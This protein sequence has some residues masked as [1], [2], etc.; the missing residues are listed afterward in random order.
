MSTASINHGDH[1]ELCE[2]LARVSTQTVSDSDSARLNALLSDDPDARAIYID[3]VAADAM[4][5]WTDN[6]AAPRDS[7]SSILIDSVVKQTADNRAGWRIAAALAIGLVIVG[8]IAAVMMTRPVEPPAPV[9]GPVVAVLS[10]SDSDVVI[11]STG[12]LAYAG[13]SLR[14]GWINVSRGTAEIAFRSGAMVRLVGPAR[15]RLDSSMNAALSSGRLAADV[16]PNAVGFTVGVGDL[17]VVDLGTKFGIEISAAGEPGVHVFQGRVRLDGRGGGKI[18]TAGSAYR[19]TAGG[20]ALIPLDRDAFSGMLIAMSDAEPPA[21]ASL[22]IWIAA[23]RGV[24]RDGEGRVRSWRDARSDIDRFAM[25]SNVAHR[26]AW[27]A[28]GIDARPAVR[29]A[30]NQHMQLPTTESLGI[31]DGYYEMFVVARTDDPAV[32]FLIA[33]SHAQGMERYELHVNG[34]TG[35]RFIPTIIK[36]AAGYADAGKQGEAVGAAH[37]LHGRV[38]GDTATAAIDGTDS[39]DTV[40]LKARESWVGELT[41]GKRGDAT[42]GLRGDIAEVLIYKVALSDENRAA[43]YEYLN[44][45]Y[46]IETQSGAPDGERN[47]D[48]ESDQS[49][50]P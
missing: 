30:G 11:E 18:V 16:P 27:T 43:V 19:A 36:D 13:T 3:Y 47:H 26:P 20:V 50:S 34:G 37:V 22:A 7:I 35:L 4:L 10:D 39:A 32:Q 23:D 33:G 12:K 14:T 24:D 46:S 28:D 25:Q 45:R 17:S 15:F 8:I 41:I 9:V 38:V 31:D 40:T 49:E 29:F 1:R 5:R 44:E 48:K 6:T 21:S 42:Y 2:L